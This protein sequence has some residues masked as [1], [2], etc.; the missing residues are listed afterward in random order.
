MFGAEALF[1]SYINGGGKENLNWYLLYVEEEMRSPT[2]LLLLLYI[3]EFFCVV[4]GMKYF[5]AIAP[6][7]S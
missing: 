6:S 5:D 2:P 4:I 7:T 1:S 3:L